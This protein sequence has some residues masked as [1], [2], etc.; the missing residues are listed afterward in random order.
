MGGTY[1][2]TIGVLRVQSK[3]CVILLCEKTW[4]SLCYLAPTDIT[5][6]P[7]VKFS[8]PYAPNPAEDSMVEAQSHI[9]ATVTQLSYTSNMAH[10]LFYW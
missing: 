4:S 10:D 1:G 7:L 5:L 8:Q 2:C 3:V 9:D 6:T